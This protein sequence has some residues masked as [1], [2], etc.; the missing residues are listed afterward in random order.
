[1]S[2]Q[3]VPLTPKESK[4]KERA[5]AIKAA[6]STYSSIK[7]VVDRV[8]A[9]KHLNPK[10]VAYIQRMSDKLAAG[11]RLTD[12]EVAGLTKIQR[13]VEATSAEAAKAYL[14][15]AKRIGEDKACEST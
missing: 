10:N 13:A 15:T 14:A 5:A 1:M 4:R 11:K 9:S 2:V 7:S 12:N 6:E 3:T 8:L